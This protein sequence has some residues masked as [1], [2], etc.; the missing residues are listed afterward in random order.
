M[1]SVA[2]WTLVGALQVGDH[3][4]YEVAQPVECVFG[5]FCQ[6]GQRRELHAGRDELA[7]FL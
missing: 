3:L 1:A 6:P 2:E 7:V 4:A 5:C